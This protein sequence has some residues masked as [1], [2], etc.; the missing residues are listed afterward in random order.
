MTYADNIKQRLNNNDSLSVVIYA[1]VSTDNDNQKESCSN[2][3]QMAM[4][5][6][7]SRTNIHIIGTYVDDGISGKND[8]TRPQY[9]SMLQQISEGNVDLI[10]TK[11]LSRLNRDQ[12]NS[13]QL[14]N[15]L[16]ST[17]TTVLTLEDN[18]IHDFEDMGSE[19][20]HSINFA[21]DAQYVK[22]QS[23]N[24]R[25]TQE[26]RCERKE[27]SAKDIS[28]GYSWDKN[29]KT[30]SIN[31]DQAE[32]V[33]RIFDEY[34]F[35]NGTPASIHRILKKE[36]INISEKTLSNII[37]DERYIGNFYINKRTTK[38]GMGQNKSKRISLPK[39]QWVLVERSDLQIV[40]TDIFQMAQ[41]LHQTRITVYVKPDKETTQSYFQGTHEYAGK[42]FCPICGKPFHFG[43]ADR[44]QTIPIYRIKNHSA[45]SSPISRIGETE[46][47]DI[48]R[49]S[50][51]MVLAQQDNVCESLEQILTECI[52]ATQNGNK[53]TDKLKKQKA[54]LEKKID[55]LINSLAEGGLTDSAKERVKNTI[56]SLTND[57]NTIS[58]TIQD[59]ENHRLDSSYV[60]DKISEI[61]TAIAEL[62]EFTTIDRTRI[63]NYIERIE[64]LPNNDLT[65]ILKSGQIINITQ[66]FPN[67]SDNNN[68]GKI[69]IRDALYSSPAAHPVPP[70]HDTLLQSPGLVS[71]EVPF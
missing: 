48:T 24:G 14:T 65:I 53:D 70:L 21:I 62:K 46:L 56:N 69:G 34:V 43:Y 10:I 61:R 58:D 29:T 22:R 64:V 45:C 57:L 19:L 28:F 30:I 51:Q 16:V 23:I 20:I 12:L 5:Y 31:P 36:N 13:L 42:I 18:Q 67:D 2:Q 26:L 50:L 66:C 35:R 52:K 71:C 32:I 4:N 11:S 15:L 59:R 33:R 63:Q 3:V 60:S 49:K 47:E 38:L 40:D 37:K 55:S 25:K 39:E 6:I 41:R 54:A 44:K 7:S 17:N 27:L 8:F 1:R 68:V 9:N